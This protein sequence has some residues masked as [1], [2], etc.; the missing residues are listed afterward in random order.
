MRDLDSLGLDPQDLEAL[1]GLSPIKK[2]KRRKLPRWVRWAAA[3]LLAVICVA[4]AELLACRHFEPELYEAVV[5]PVRETARQASRALQRAWG[6]VCRA[7]SAAAGGIGQAASALADRAGEARDS[8]RAWMEAHSAP[9]PEEAEDGEMDGPLAQPEIAPPMEMLNPLISNLVERDGLRV[10]TGGGV[11]V[12]Y[13]NQTDEAR[14]DQKYGSDP[15]STHG[16]GP[17]AMA[18]VVSTLRPENVT[19]IDMAN[20]CTESGYWANRQGSYLS[21]VNGVADAYSLTCTSLPPA[22]LNHD[23]FKARLNSGHLAV[24]LM[25]KGHF[26]TSGHFIVLRGTTADGKILVSDPASLER[27]LTPWDLQLILDE[28]SYSRSA[29]SPLWLLSYDVPTG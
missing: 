11:D 16:C 25:R 15:L 14:A 29:G 9:P 2:H 13:Y 26:T 18:M 21:I 27:S 23:D 8:F 22:E 6:G 12:V 3:V 19:P 24:A 20:F 7:G 28:L 10:L 5:E 17:T 1:Y 4:G